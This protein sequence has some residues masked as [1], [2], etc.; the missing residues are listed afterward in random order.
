M[1]AAKGR[2]PGARWRKV[3]EA[4]LQFESRNRY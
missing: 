3:A 1:W 2:F 4:Q